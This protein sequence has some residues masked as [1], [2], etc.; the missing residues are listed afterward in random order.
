MPTHLNRWHALLP[1]LDLISLAMACLFLKHVQTLLRRNKLRPIFSYLNKIVAILDG[2]INFSSC[3]LA[4][5]LSSLAQCSHTR[6]E[7]LL[8]INFSPVSKKMILN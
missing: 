3:L 8:Q 1:S 7:A 5:L 6:H 4:R 2:V